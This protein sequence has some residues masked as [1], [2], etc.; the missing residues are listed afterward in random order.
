MFLD[1]G[2][3]GLRPEVCA[4]QLVRPCSIG[5]ARCLHVLTFKHRRSAV[6]RGT[7]RKGRG[8][9]HTRNKRIPKRETMAAAA[10]RGCRTVSPEPAVAAPA[11]QV[12]FQRL[13]ASVW[14]PDFIVP[15]AGF[16]PLAGP[17]S[18]VLL[19]RLRAWDS[20]EEAALYDLLMLLMERC[21]S[22]GLGA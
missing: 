10:A 22:P 2:I 3:L 8:T 7:C 18:E 1:D 17:G 20:S 16:Q 15:D 12:L 4:D 21:A 5:T 9:I 11:L 14:V 6:A 19:A 13:G